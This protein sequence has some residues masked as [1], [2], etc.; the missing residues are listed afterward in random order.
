MVCGHT[1]ADWSARPGKAD[2]A[3]PATQVSEECEDP[4]MPEAAGAG[5]GA[6]AG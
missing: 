2:F 5:A 1:A 3:R 6:G 4:D